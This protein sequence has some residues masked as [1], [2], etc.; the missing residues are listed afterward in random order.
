M[1]LSNP[2]M[3]FTISDA[4][5]T[6]GMPLCMDPV[7]QNYQTG[8]NGCK[9]AQVPA[10]DTAI[11]TST[12]FSLYASAI[13]QPT[14]DFY[15]LNFTSDMMIG[16]STA[17]PQ[18]TQDLGSSFL[19]NLTM[20]NCAVTT[21]KGRQ[22]SS[23][24]QIYYGDYVQLSVMS[25]TTRYYFS[26]DYQGHG[27]NAFTTSPGN[28]GKDIQTFQILKVGSG[29]DISV[30]NNSPVLLNDVLALVAVGPG[31]PKYTTI[32]AAPHGVG[33]NPPGTGA[34]LL[35]SQ[36]ALPQH[37]T[38]TEKKTLPLSAVEFATE[39][40][41]HNPPPINLFDIIGWIIVAITVIVLILYILK[42]MKKI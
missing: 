14:P 34:G 19:F 11:T 4:T 30:S 2:G 37:G 31:N 39:Y 18:K 35:G 16:A 26:P 36:A 13:P 33:G 23:G 22:T 28:C 24:I 12:T 25:G 41:K 1:S 7:A 8:I 42:R 6:S 20:E 27:K 21:E 9:Y 3:K 40:K 17:N 29:N 5:G 32:V 10:G 15:F 38:D